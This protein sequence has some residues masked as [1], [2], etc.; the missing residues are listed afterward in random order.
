MVTFVKTK[1]L[2]QLSVSEAELRGTVCGKAAR[3][4]LWGSGE[5][6]NRSTRRKVERWK[7]G[8]VEDWKNRK[9]EKWENGI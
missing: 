8:K 9:V 1:N 2:S 7:S 3:T 4:G 5:E 6:T